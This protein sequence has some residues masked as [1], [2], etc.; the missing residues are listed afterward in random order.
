MDGG[1]RR[2]VADLGEAISAHIG[3]H[4]GSTDVDELGGHG[5]VRLHGATA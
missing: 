4:N 2:D 1:F 3:G 5:M